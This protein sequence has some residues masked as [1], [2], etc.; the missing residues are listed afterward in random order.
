MMTDNDPDPDPAQLWPRRWARQ[1]RQTQPN[2]PVTQA[3]HWA[4]ANWTVTQTKD[5]ARPSPID[6]VASGHYYCGQPS[7]MTQWLGRPSYWTIQWTQP[8]WRPNDG[9]LWP[10]PMKAE[11]SDVTLIGQ[12]PRHYWWQPVNDWPRHCGHWTQAND[13][14]YWGQAIDPAQWPRPSEPVAS[15]DG[16]RTVMTVG[17]WR[18]Y[19]WPDYWPQAQPV[20]YWLTDP[21][22]EI[23]EVIIE[24]PMDNWTVASDPGL[25]QTQLLLNWVIDGIG[26]ESYLLL[27]LPSYC[28]RTAR[29]DII[30]AR[31]GQTRPSQPD[32]QP[33]GPARQPDGPVDSDPALL[34]RCSYY[35][36]TCDDWPRPMT[37]P[38]ARPS[39]RRPNDPIDS[40][41]GPNCE[42]DGQW[43]NCGQ[44][45]WYYWLLVIDIDP[46]D[47][48]CDD[49]QPSDGPSDPIDGRRQ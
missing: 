34:A 27:L 40:P 5:P 6:P 32:G 2:D 47:N 1:W 44:Y 38:L 11:P 14:Q 24:W 3:S 16:R 8:D 43:P 30:V 48:Y 9:K 12:W 46:I 37:R 42:P 28:G 41:I 45:W 21:V 7:P 39:W 49:D 20:N 4:Q 17:Y 29:T 33:S 19:Y 25:T 18:R 22:I 13:G 15:I 26:I 36:L 23:E 10:D 31:T 35:W